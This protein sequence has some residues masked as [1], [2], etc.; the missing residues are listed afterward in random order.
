[1]RHT[2]I[3]RDQELDE[4]GRLVQAVSSE[5][6]DVS[7]FAIRH[8]TQPLHLTLTARTLRDDE[9]SDTLVA[10]DRLPGQVHLRPEPP[11]TTD[12]ARLEVSDLMTGTTVPPGMDV[13]TLPYAIL[14]SRRIWRQ[15]PLRIYLEMYHLGQEGGSAHLEALF[16]VIPLDDAG[17]V[18]DEREVIALDFQAEPIGATYREFF[19][20]ALR[21]QRPGRYRLQVEITDRVRNQTVRRQAV[22]ELVD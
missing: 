19:D 7:S 10:S 18:D 13:S 6:A 4:V 22:F 5:R 11:L 15:D 16:R 3:I 9:E 2:L 14:P 17:E 1:M 8:V 21:D 12:T 20:V